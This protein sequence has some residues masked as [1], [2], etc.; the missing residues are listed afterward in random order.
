MPHAFHT[1]ANLSQYCSML[2]KIYHIPHLL[3]GLKLGLAWDM[4]QIFSI[5]HI[6]HIYCGCS[7][8]SYILLVAMALK[9]ELDQ[10]IQPVQ[11][12]IKYQSGLIK[13]LKIEKNWEL[14]ANLV[15]PSVQF[16]KCLVFYCQILLFLNPI[17]IIIII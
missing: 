10:P 7:N 14:E 9:I 4:C 12:E 15:L 6:S 17:I 2:Q 5:W 1:V 3:N 13:M 11:L 16:L 8:K